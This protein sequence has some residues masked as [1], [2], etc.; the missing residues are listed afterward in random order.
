MIDPLRSRL[1]ESNAAAS[2]RYDRSRVTPGIVHLGLG[3]FHRAHMAAYIDDLLGADPNWGIIGASLKRPDTRDALA[4]Q[5][6][7]YTL[8]MRGGSETR[9]RIVGALL[10]I[11]HAGSHRRNLL[12]WMTDPAIRIVSLTVTE[13]GYC[14]DPAT[15]RLSFDHP[16]IIHDLAAPDNPVSA[17]GLV[18]RALDLR[19]AAGI[20]PFTVLSCDNLPENGRTTAA[21]VTEFAAR[22][23][24]KLARHIEADVAFPSTMV[25][26]IVPATTEEDRTSVAEATGRYDAWPVVTEP[27]TQWV[28]ED[29]FTAQ[30]PS[31]ETVGVELV[32]D[33]RPHELKKLRMLNGSHSMLAYLGYL[34]GFEFIS[35]TVADPAFRDLAHTFMTSE[36]ME[37]LPPNIGDL[38]AYRDALL[39]R[40]ANPA[41]KHRTWQIAMDGSQKLPQRLLGTIRDRLRLGLP[42][43]RGA[44]AVAAWMRY[45]SGID[46]TGRAIDVRDP[47]SARLRAIARSGGSPDNLVDG[48][49]KVHEVFDTPLAQ[50][51][52]FRTALIDHLESLVHLGA[53]Q[54]VRSLAL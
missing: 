50:A 41:L 18:A 28:I 33:V 25:D 48:F 39:D 3:A 9:Y 15:G 19:R 53:A 10:D 32:A 11:L 29:R 27:F 47:L 30:R 40:F 16:D 6:F 13:K 22:R 38:A 4:P 51:P 2:I 7:L 43:S 36:V 24:E 8:V 34:A 12:R 35:D 37:T 46:E 49:L 5:D 45:V 23:D 42:I 54:T 17:P 44:L 31:F 20:V 1:S 26:R 14:H 21:I 52:D